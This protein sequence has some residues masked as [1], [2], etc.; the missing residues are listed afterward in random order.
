MTFLQKI[1]NHWKIGLCLVN[2]GSDNKQRLTKLAENRASIRDIEGI[3][4]SI[5]NI[6]ERLESAAR[7]IADAEIS[8]G[9]FRCE[10]T[11]SLLNFLAYHGRILYDAIITDQVDAGWLPHHI[12]RVQLVCAHAEAFLPLEFL[13]EKPTPSLD[14]KLCPRS[15][16]ALKEGNCKDCLLNDDLKNIPYICPIGFWCMSRVIER[17]AHDAS[18][19]TILGSSDYV[20]QSEPVDDRMDLQ[21]LRTCLYAASN[22]VD[23]VVPGQTRQFLKTLDSVSSNPGIMVSMWDDWAKE[24]ASKHPTLLILMPH[25]LEDETLRAPVMEIGA[26]DRLVSGHI[27]PGYVCTSPEYQPPIVALLGCETMVPYSKYMGFVPQ[28]RRNGAALV[29]STLTTV[30]GRQVVPIAQK[31]VEELKM[32]LDEAEGHAISFGDVLLNVRRKI[33]LQGLPIVLCLI[34]FGDADWRLVSGKK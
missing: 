6:Q 28:F 5:R 11:E 24:V 16:Q 22:R 10:E 19:G 12:G 13:Y 27:R 32:E 25:T 23:S 2:H 29:L 17:H 33:M 1:R 20:M 34:A 8:E 26:S 9:I 30:L 31:L 18:Y 4:T 3:Q 14:A 7:A 21:V 15:E